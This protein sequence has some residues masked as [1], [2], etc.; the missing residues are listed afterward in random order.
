MKSKIYQHAKNCK[1]FLYKALLLFESLLISNLSYSQ[2]TN[3]TASL[4]EML[5]NINQ[6]GVTSGIIYERTVQFADLYNFNKAADYK[7]A[8]SKIFVQALA[9]LYNASN[10]TEFISN[11]AFK[12]LIKTTYQDNV[13][14][15]GIIN[16][17]FQ[18]LN[19]S[20]PP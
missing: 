11:D 1:C 13:V 20:F 7:T 3:T 5:S 6:S 14:D 12:N 17:P 8:N 4:D 16:T 9:E 10:K 15:I 18:A 2:T 19:Y